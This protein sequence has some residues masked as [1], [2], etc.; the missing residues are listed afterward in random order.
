MLTVLAI[1]FMTAAYLILGRIGM[2]RLGRERRALTMPD[3]PPLV[4]IVIPA[5][6]S[7]KTIGS[8]L[9]SARAL[10]Y[11]RKEIIV[12]NDSMDSTPEIARSY[13]A[14]VIQNQKRMGKPASLNRAT[15]EAKG[16]LLFIL[17]SDTTASRSCLQ[18]MVPWFSKREVAAVMPRYLLKNRGPISKLAGL[19]NLFTF[20]LLRVHAFFG[21][22]V[23]FRGC[24][25]LIRRDILRKHPWPDT[26][27]EDNHLSATLAG[28][29]HRI[30][31][32]PLAVT[33]TTEPESLQELKR[34]KR[35]WGEGAG[36]A[37]LHH[38][39]FYMR[40]PQ[41]LLFFFPYLSMGIIAGLLFI[42]L[43]L[44]PLLFPSLAAPIL[45][46]LALIFVS[47]YA[48]ALIFLY[49][50]GGR[51]MPLGTLRFM[52]FYFPVATAYYFRGLLSGIKRKKKRRPELH[53]RHW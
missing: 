14:G 4:S 42:S 11:P 18:R 29:G 10:D 34:Q 3:R 32:E 45:K 47:M 48:H 49:V 15:S 5:Y 50:G 27:M 31:W 24:S 38:R 53:F 17:D 44:S 7:Q 2:S 51:P 40:S 16:E 39:R 52:L 19:E 21:G 20:S 35:R 43:L 33:H 13:G 25:V 1:A 26:L 8:T 9:K 41:F 23:G 6:N 28:Q 30:I 37:F 22:T 12:V 36:L 46:E